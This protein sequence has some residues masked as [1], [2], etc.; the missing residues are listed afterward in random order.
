VLILN[1]PKRESRKRSYLGVA[2]LRILI[3]YENIQQGRQSAG[4]PDA[5]E[6]KNASSPGAPVGR[7]QHLD[8]IACDC[9]LILVLDYFRIQDALGA[10]AF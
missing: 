10:I 4:I 1:L 3:A 9:A 2:I 7:E 8:K 5:A 6:R